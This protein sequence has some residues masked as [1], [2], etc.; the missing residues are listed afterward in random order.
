[1]TDTTPAKPLPTITDENR[2]FWDGCAAGELRMQEC[3]SCAHV[4]YPIQ[5]LCPRCL[6]T[7]FTWR[8]LSG[9]GE[10]FAHAVYHRAFHPAYAADVPYDLVLVQ[11]D[12]GPR[13][14]SNVVDGE[15]RVG[16]RLAVVFD[17]VADGIHL[18]RF[19]HVKEA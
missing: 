1:M 11:L 19:R 9:R 3:S 8:T 12:E 18:P 2:P 4:R 16:D 10:V 5:P 13:M 17:E 7:E 6:A 14:Y 15:V